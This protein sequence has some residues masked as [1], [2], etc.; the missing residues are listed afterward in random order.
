MKAPE[1]IW[2]NGEY[3]VDKKPDLT[4]E[5]VDIAVE[6][7][8]AELVLCEL[9]DM[10]NQHCSQCDGEYLDSMALSANADAMRLLA[11]LGVIEITKEYG[12]R[13]IGQFTEKAQEYY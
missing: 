13:V 5:M 4:P 2:L 1:R 10:V 3:W 12:R 9:I 6:Y 8:H 11:K 7:V